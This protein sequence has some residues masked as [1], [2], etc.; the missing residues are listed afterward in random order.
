MP[1][2]A[3][4]GYSDLYFIDGRYSRNGRTKYTFRVRRAGGAHLAQPGHLWSMVDVSSAAGS[5]P[6]VSCS[7]VLIPRSVPARETST[8]APAFAGTSRFSS[9]AT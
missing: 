7:R 2:C 9:D 1:R 3:L 4:N 5:M 6:S 8:M